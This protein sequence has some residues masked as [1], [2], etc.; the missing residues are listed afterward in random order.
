MKTK[1][2]TKN[3]NEEY[4]VALHVLSWWSV[5][6]SFNHEFVQH[7]DETDFIKNPLRISSIRHFR[8]T[9]CYSSAS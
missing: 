4:Y 3:E 5:R 6:I 1:T 9:N 2:K 7:F 8:L